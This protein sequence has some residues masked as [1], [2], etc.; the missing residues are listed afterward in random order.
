[1]KIEIHYNYLERF[2]SQIQAEGRLSFSLTELTKHFSSQSNTALKHALNRLKKKNKIV[3]VYKGFYLII[4]PE[5]SKRKILPPELFIDALFKYLN[6]PYYIALAS[7]AALYGAAHQKILV[8]SVIISKPPLRSTK[9]ENIFINYIVKSNFP[10]NGI[11]Q[12]KTET[13][14]INVSSP[15]LTVIDLVL[16]NYHVGSFERVIQIIY[17]LSDAISQNNMKMLIKSID[18]PIAVLQR[19]GFIFDLIE[20]S[21]LSAVVYDFLSNNKLR[22]VPLHPSSNKNKL[23]DLEVNHKWKIIVNLDLQLELE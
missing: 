17:Q 1:M 15:E 14:F 2:I 4:P 9:G 19:L 21:E 7:A 10:A 20:L 18:I 11:Q 12:L 16:Y 23:N 6:R 22:N 3:S 13:G 5:Y 8:T